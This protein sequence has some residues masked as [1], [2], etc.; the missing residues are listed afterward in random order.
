VVDLKEK[1]NRQLN[2]KLKSQE[3]AEEASGLA[4]EETPVA[5]GDAD[6]IDLTEQE[7]V[8][9]LAPIPIDSG[10]IRATAVSQQRSDFDNALKKE[11]E[12][13]LD[14]RLDENL[15]DGA[16][17]IAKREI[18]GMAAALGMDGDSI[19]ER[20]NEWLFTLDV[21]EVGWDP[22][23]H[24]R[25][26]HLA[27]AKWADLARIGLRYASIGTSEASVERLLGEQK[28]VQGRHGVNFGTETLHARLVLR[29]EERKQKV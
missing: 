18:R 5:V 25:E 13:T 20:F 21:C 12:K 19:V 17:E 27:Q 1:F 2:P 10:D 16:Y 23:R 28:E 9:L 3:R 7:V 11:S 14:E 22:D 24:W 4:T 26:V 15:T 29:H 8:G 6:Q